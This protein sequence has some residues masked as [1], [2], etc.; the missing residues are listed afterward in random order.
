MV[1]LV[2]PR[3]NQAI[4]Q[5][6]TLPL[7]RLQGVDDWGDLHEVGPCSGDQI[8]ALYHV[9]RLVPVSFGLW[10]IR[11]FLLAHTPARVAECLRHRG[12]T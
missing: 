9:A 11:Q 1:R 12:T 2:L 10:L 4:A 8:N 5:R 3:M 6:P 7:R